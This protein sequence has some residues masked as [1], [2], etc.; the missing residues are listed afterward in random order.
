MIA[1]ARDDT[2]LV[3]RWWWTVDRWML[4]A[5]VLLMGAGVIVAMA[6]SPAAAERLGHDA[7]YFARRQI[8]FAGAALAIVLVVSLLSPAGVRRAALVLFA[9]ALAAVGLTLVSG[10]EINGA[11]RWLGLAG[12][13]VQPSEFVKPAFV[14]LTAWLAARDRAEPGFPGTA[15]SG[16]LS[17]LVIGLLLLQP[18]FSMA[19]MIA[20]VWFAQHFFAGMRLRW[21]ALGAVASLVG[22]VAA[23]AAMPHVAT[24]IDRFLDPA[25]GDTYQVDTARQA[26]MNGGLLGRGPGEGVVKDALPDAQSDFVFA[27]AGEEFGA[28]AS[29]G[30]IAVFA[31]VVLRGLARALRD[32]SLFVLLAAG[33]LFTQF[34]LQAV[35]HMAV[36]LALVPPTGMTLPLVS[37]GG[38]SALAVAL[39][40]GMALALMRRRP[41]PAE[42]LP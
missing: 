34:G 10:V 2:S 42:A 23:Y 1:V 39:G 20:A 18:D 13:T 22:V 35:F 9:V 12:L 26:F 31:F 7:F 33:G 37:Y 24:R 38:S 8:A 11:R 32:S 3:G 30:L 36:T 25:T 19:A 41:E 21:V 4:A 40:M 14:V 6:A 29:V 27:V 17:A 15:I 5:L 28:L 16:A